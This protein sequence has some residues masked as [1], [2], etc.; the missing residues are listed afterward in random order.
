MKIII[1]ILIFLLVTFQLYAQN[2]T[3]NLNQS[4]SIVSGNY[5]VSEYITSNGVVVNNGNVVYDAGKSIDLKPS[6]IVDAAKGSLFKVT[7][8]IIALLE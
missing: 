2:C 7:K 8:T 4:G 6:F 3:P 5:K 1:K